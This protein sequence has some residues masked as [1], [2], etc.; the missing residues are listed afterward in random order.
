MQLPDAY[1]T[2]CQ[3]S[4]VQHCM[5]IQEKYVDIGLVASVVY[6]R[7]VLELSLMTKST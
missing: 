7:H 3:P 1:V 4:K 2:I 5:Y 6:G